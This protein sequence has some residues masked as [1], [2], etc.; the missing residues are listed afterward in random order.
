MTRAENER[1]LLQQIAD[2][3]EAL[4]TAAQIL[5]DPTRTAHDARNA[6]AVEVGKALGVLTYDWRES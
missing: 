1:L 2:A 3:H 4:G 6:A 5:A